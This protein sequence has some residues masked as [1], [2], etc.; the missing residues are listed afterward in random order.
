MN[1]YR[2]TGGQLDWHVIAAAVP[3]R[4]AQ[5]AQALYYRLHPVH[6]LV[7]IRAPTAPISPPPVLYAFAYFRTG[8]PIEP[9]V[10]RIRAAAALRLKR[11]SRQM[12]RSPAE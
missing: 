4:S 12:A 9:L 6:T 2:A 7:R 8:E 11:S 10:R 1:E 3:G 5:A